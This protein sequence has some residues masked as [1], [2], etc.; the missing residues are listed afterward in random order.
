MREIGFRG[1]SIDTGRWVYGSLILRECDMYVDTYVK[2]YGY[3][4]LE[5]EVDQS[6]VGQYTGLKDKNGV[7][8]Y[9]GDIVLCRGYNGQMKATVVFSHG[10]FNVG[11]HQGS[12][13]KK[14]PILLNPKMEVI[15]NVHDNPEL[16]T[17]N[18]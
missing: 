15:G 3:Y 12:S 2:E 11:F 10:C 16:L 14:T 13:T 9:E 1:K 8:I 6:T 17:N 7:E 4:S 18:E 5:K